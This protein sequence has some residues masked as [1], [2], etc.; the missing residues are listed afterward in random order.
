[1]ILLGAAT[2]MHICPLLMTGNDVSR[3]DCN[4]IV[5]MLFHWLLHVAKGKPGFPLGALV[6]Q[7]DFHGNHATQ[8]TS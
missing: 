8:V 2:A 1:M 5:L 7:H 6:Q 4:L 3:Q